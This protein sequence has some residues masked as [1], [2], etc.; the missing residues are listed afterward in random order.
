MG[1]YP[2]NTSSFGYTPRRLMSSLYE[3]GN[4]NADSPVLFY[5]LSNPLVQA[6]QAYGEW[7]M[8]SRFG[9]TPEEYLSGASLYPGEERALTQYALGDEPSYYTQW[10]LRQPS[11]LAA[12]A[13][14]GGQDLGGSNGGNPTGTTGLGGNV[15]SNIIGNMRGVSASPPTNAGDDSIFNSLFAIGAEPYVDSQGNLKK[16]VKTKPG[17]GVDL[18]SLPPAIQ[19]SLSLSPEIMQQYQFMQSPS[20][21]QAP[22]PVPQITFGGAAEQGAPISGVGG[23]AGSMMSGLNL[24][25]IQDSIRSWLAQHGN[26]RRNQEA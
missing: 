5:N 15:L 10:L 9:S 25:G 12:L 14:L 11:T 1:S 23:G 7:N 4:L 8:G 26:G 17:V 20:M 3:R 19:S 16:N 24:S 13:Q 2:M 21:A 22:A 6:A 18:T